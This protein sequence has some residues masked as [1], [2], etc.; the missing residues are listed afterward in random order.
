MSSASLLVLKTNAQQSRRVT[1]TNRPVHACTITVHVSVQTVQLC[2]FQGWI[3][4]WTP[5]LR[6][7]QNNHKETQDIPKEMQNNHEE[8]ITKEPKITTERCNN[9]TVTTTTKRKKSSLD[10]FEL[11][12]NSLELIHILIQYIVS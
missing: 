6:G 5:D 11:V 9:Y 12:H 7:M 1:D 8:M 3:T 10:K 2:Y 4:E